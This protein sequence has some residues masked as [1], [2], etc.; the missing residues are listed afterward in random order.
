MPRS[1]KLD[2]NSIISK[3]VAPALEE[4]PAAPASVPEVKAPATV[5]P[6]RPRLVTAE[7][8]GQGTL[9]QRAKQMTVYLEEP[10]YDQLR[11]LAHTERT[12]LHP[13]I[14]EAIDLLLKKRG[15]PS[16]KEL[17]KKAS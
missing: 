10:V 14:L 12:K 9:K 1:P 5:A 13:L 11:E 16:I 6:A 3:D 2:F 7:P 17:L 4:A 15:A 8:K